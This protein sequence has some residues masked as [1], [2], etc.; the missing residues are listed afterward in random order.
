MSDSIVIIGRETPGGPPPG[1]G[2][3][4]SM[5]W[6]HN[7]PPKDFQ[8]SFAGKTV[9]VTGANV[10]LGFEAAVKYAALG[11]DKLILAV[12]TLA[13]GEEAKKRIVQ[14][15]GRK[16]TDFIV[17]IADLSDFASVKAFVAAL[18]RATQHLDVALLNAGMG[19]PSFA[20]SSFGWEMSVQVNVLSTTLM[21]LSLLPLLRRT[22]AVRRT[23]VHM[24]FVNS[25]GHDRVKK[26]WLTEADESL[27]RASNDPQK[28]DAFRSY[29]MVKLMGMAVMQTIAQATKSSASEGQGGVIVNAVCP[30]LCKTQLGRNFGL[31]SKIT[32]TVFQAIFARSAE[33]GARSLVSATALGLE[34]QGRLW[35][36]DVLFP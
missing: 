6:S 35:H 12:R 17:L 26:E 36:H 9:L 32:G 19:N 29:C 33:E 21:A 13:K 4:A 22:A 2:E 31:M 11:A 5:R 16:M 8:I 34:S 10:G 24:T 15:S 30:G 25:N 14:R 18:G 7:N 20:K 23:A 28:W 1:L 27:L 3:M